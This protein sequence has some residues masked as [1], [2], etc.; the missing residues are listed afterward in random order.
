MDA[1]E[2]VKKRVRLG[3]KT[4]ADFRL[5]AESQRGQAPG[6]TGFAWRNESGRG[7]CP[8]QDTGGEI[9]SRTRESIRC[10]GKLKETTNAMA[11]VGIAG[12]EVDCVLRGVS[13]VLHLQQVSVYYIWGPLAGGA[14]RDDVSSFSSTNPVLSGLFLFLP[15]RQIEFEDVGVEEIHRNFDAVQVRNCELGVSLSGFFSFFLPLSQKKRTTT[16]GVMD[17]NAGAVSPFSTARMFLL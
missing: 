8:S 4:A 10:R 9:P 14:S 15:R 12:T 1:D 7:S 2:E 11:A 6:G 17:C 16:N 3:G 13:A 5:T